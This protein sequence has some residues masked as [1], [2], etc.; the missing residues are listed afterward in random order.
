MNKPITK[1]IN[2]IK[3][4]SYDFELTDTHVLSPSNVVYWWICL[5]MTFEVNICSRQYI[6]WTETS[7]KGQGD[8]R[9][10]YEK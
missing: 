9:Y 3:I 5:D 6:F 8:N 2:T 7:S 4:V 1:S 10:I